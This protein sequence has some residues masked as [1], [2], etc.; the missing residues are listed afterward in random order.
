MLIKFNLR[1]INWFTL[2][3]HLPLFTHIYGELKIFNKFLNKFDLIWQFCFFL[4]RSWL[5]SIMS[6]VHHEVRRLWF[7]ARTYILFLHLFRFSFPP[8]LSPRPFHSLFSQL[9][10]SFIHFL[11]KCLVMSLIQAT[12]SSRSGISRNSHKSTVPEIAGG[13]LV[14]FEGFTH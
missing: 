3:T 5:Y 14:N 2:F 7:S 8:L 6:D 4:C 9:T 13:I 10:P 11:C 1:S 12:G